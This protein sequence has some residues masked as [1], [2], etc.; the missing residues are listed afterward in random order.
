MLLM[1]AIDMRDTRYFIAAHILLVAIAV[2]GA[3]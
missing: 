1:P 2:F 3:M